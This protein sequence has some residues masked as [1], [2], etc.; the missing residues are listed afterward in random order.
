MVVGELPDFGK[1]SFSGELR[2]S[3][4]A[5]TSVIIPQLEEGNKRLH[6]VAPPGSGKTVL[7][8]FVWAELVRKPTLVLSPNSAIQA[9][10]AARTSLFNLDGKDSFISTNPKSPGLLTSLTYQSVTLP[11]KGGKDLDAAALD[12]W[13]EKLIAEGEADD[14]ESAVAWQNDLRERNSKYYKSRISSYRKR[15]RDEIS[16]DGD[17]LGTLHKSAKENL[18]LLKEAGIGLIILDECHHLMHHWGRILSEIREMFDDPYVLGLT[19]TPPEGDSFKDED[20]KRYVEFF[21]PVDYEV[22]VPALVRDSNLA[23]YQDLCYFVRPAPHE[24]EYI[25]RVD[26]EFDELLEELR[27]SDTELV[28]GK[29]PS[30][31]VWLRNALEERRSPGGKSEDWSKF[32]SKNKA[33]AD[34]SRRYLQLHGIELPSGVPK[35]VMLKGDQSWTRMSM[36]RTVL[37]RYVRHG[38]RRSE[39]SDDHV[40]SESV[41]SRLRLLGIQ[42][43]ETGSRPCASPVGRVMAYASAKVDALNEIITV[44]SKAMG[45]DIRVVV[46]TDFEKTSATALVEGVLDDE[47]GGA[48][49]VFRT[50]VS[51][52]AGDTLDPVLMTGSTVLVDD[53]LIDRFITRAEEWARSRDL[54]IEFTDIIHDGYHEIRGKGKNWIP[55]YYSLMITEFFQEGLTRCIVGTRGLLG[56]GWD[57]S[58]INVL[59]D[60]TTVTT[61][62]SINQLRGRS[63]RLDSMWPEKVANNWDIICLAEEFTKGFDDYERFKRKH[64]QL[65]GV[66]DDGTIEKGV[67]HVHAAFNDARPEGISEGMVLFN[68]EMLKRAQTRPHTRN[69][70]GIGKPFAATSTRALEA[71]LGT[72]FG[73]GFNF[74]KEKK[75]WTDESLIQ[76][77]SKVIVDSLKELSEVSSHC[78]PIGGDRGGGWL[79]YH[80]HDSSAEEAKMFSDS[81]KE[82]LGPLT[83]PRYVISRSSRFMK[84]TWLSKMMPEVLARFLRKTKSEIRMYHTVP[85]CM[86]SSKERAMVFQKHWNQHIGPS[87]L[88]YGRSAT[89]KQFVE[90]IRQSGL[91]PE[92]GLHSKQVFI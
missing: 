26:E 48:I 8:L 70:W 3:Q 82:L 59:I 34:D 4:K 9:Q 77:F 88:R 20:V 32:Q 19:A 41:V 67:G 7:G 29:V 10:W 61:S 56:E 74:G 46:V 14:H 37:D 50:L 51:H 31:D 2:H 72:G 62:M 24:L 89:G 86:A 54:E 73:G 58:R 36:L 53:E 80:L 27:A 23:P 55:R 1:I 45:D 87:E 66:C 63:I 35:I 42:I 17:I 21:G 11:Q 39:N 30:L 84:D 16:K 28:E 12:L 5:A 92:V 47:A 6:I 75:I 83:S 64:Q 22:P 65:Y 49:A 90:T 85:S 38:L 33:F 91:V 44:E 15:A 78:S 69:L 81:L 52:P 13:A 57:A 18:R 40:L 79:R 71:K 60:M 76:A 25:A 68:D 43:T